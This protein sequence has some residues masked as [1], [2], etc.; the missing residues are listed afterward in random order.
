[1]ASEHGLGVAPGARIAVS[2]PAQA[3]IAPKPSPHRARIDSGCRP[4]IHPGSTPDRCMIDSARPRI[5]PGR[6]P[7]R[8]WIE[9][10]S[11]PDRADDESSP[12]RP[13]TSSPRRP[14]VEPTP[15]PPRASASSPDRPHSRTQLS[16]QI[17]PGSRSIPGLNRHRIAPSRSLGAPS[18][19]THGDL[20]HLRQAG[21]D[22]AAPQGPGLGQGHDDL[23]GRRAAGEER[24]HIAPLHLGRANGW[25]SDR[26]V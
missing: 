13:P 12:D 1:M 9:P 19:P 26:R 22:H 6:G 23:P 2:S 24:L 25:C 11:T 21:L 5:D 16:A 15:T 4:Q 20:S 18:D 3:R 7:N 17:D 8:S 10:E 14:R